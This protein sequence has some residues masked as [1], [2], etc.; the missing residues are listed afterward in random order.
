MHT[1]NCIV[2][3]YTKSM[4]RQIIM[5]Q[6]L[7]WILLIAPWFLLIPLDSKRLSRFLSVAFFTVLI[8]TIHFQMAQVWNWWTVT[9]NVFFLTNVSSFTYGLLPVT[10]IL[11]FYFTY[12]KFW[13]FF[14]ANLVMDAIQAFI[15]SPFVFERVGLYKMN[16][17]SNFGL[18]LLLYSIVPIIYIYQRWYD[19]A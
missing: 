9:N 17:M 11:V 4:W 18:F 8:D 10:T 6:L 14:G 19:K 13:L 3:Q 1:V 2:R 15:I 16:N 12:R 7:S 5:A